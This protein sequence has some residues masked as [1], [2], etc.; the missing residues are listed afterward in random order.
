M[1]TD[2][3]SS[4]LSGDVVERIRALE[5]FARQRVEGSRLGDNRSPLLGVSPEFVQHRAYLPGDNLRHVDWRIVAKTDR[6]MTKR[7]AEFT[8]TRAAVALD[9]SGSMAYQGAGMSK[10]EYALRAAAILFYLMSL[11]RDAFSLCLMEGKGLEWTDSASSRRHLALV[12]ER[13]LSARPQGAAE[14]P[15]TIERLGHRLRGRGLLIVISDFM[16]DPMAIAT[17]IGRLRVRGQDVIA[18]QVFDAGERDIDFVDFTQFRDLED[19][20]LIAADPLLI[21][22]EYRRHFLAHQLQL[23]EQCLAHG[24]D[25]AALEVSD[26][27]EIL[28]GDYLRRRAAGGR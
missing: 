7:F 15:T 13:L 20:S 21:R 9:I 19:G 8:N 28:I 4:I 10:H 27:Y 16:D 24:V 25:F 22:E 5:L 26:H 17:A 11:Q 14:L 23:K 3:I 1:A 6:M 2:A 12:F 18:F